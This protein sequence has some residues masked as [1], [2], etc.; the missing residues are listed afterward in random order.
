MWRAPQHLMQRFPQLSHSARP[1]ALQPGQEMTAAARHARHGDCPFPLQDRQ[2]R[3]PIPFGSISLPC[4]PH[5][6]HGEPPDPA[7]AVQRT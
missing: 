6:R 2:T 5:S 1:V 3:M 4:P 7:Q